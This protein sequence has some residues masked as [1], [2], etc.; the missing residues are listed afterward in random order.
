M[1]PQRTIEF[2]QQFA[3]NGTTRKKNTAN[4][5]ILTASH[6]LILMTGF[7][8]RTGASKQSFFAVKGLL[9][10]TFKYSEQEGGERGRGGQA[11]E[12]E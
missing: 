4:V 5:L 3:H 7:A 2:T 9:T 1:A 10:Q 11:E 6:M 8:R 12:F